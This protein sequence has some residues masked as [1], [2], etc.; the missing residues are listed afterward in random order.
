MEILYGL[1]QFFRIR[2]AENCRLTLSE[3]IV[4]FSRSAAGAA[5]LTGAASYEIPA[6]LLD[7]SVIKLMK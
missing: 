5:A 7:A 1:L 3:L 4:S 6:N 2:V